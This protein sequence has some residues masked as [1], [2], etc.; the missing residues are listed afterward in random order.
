M[1]SIHM[2]QTAVALFAIA[3]LG[4]LLMAGIRFGGKRNP[5]T[6]LAMVHGLL[7]ASGLTLV[8]YAAC[9]TGLP[10]LAQIGLVLLLLAAAGGA[11]LNLAYHW[12]QRPLPAGLTVGHALLA[13]VGFALLV[14]AAFA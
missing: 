2:L 12:K 9:T 8:L 5:P 11:Y 3:A 14:A 10:R 6:W 13:V 7:G 1:D 4:G